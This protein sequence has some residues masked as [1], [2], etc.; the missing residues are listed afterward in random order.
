MSKEVKQA[1]PKPEQP[2][3]D[4]F[5]DL[6]AEAEAKGSVAFEVPGLGVGAKPA[7]RV[8]H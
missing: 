2:K 3:A 4:E 1:D 7:L 5:A 6:K 8:D